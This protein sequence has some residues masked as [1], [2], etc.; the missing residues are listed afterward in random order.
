[1]IRGGSGGGRHF[2][3]G[4]K[5]IC[6]GL[7]IGGAPFGSRVA[8]I[9]LTCM[10]GPEAPLDEKE[11]PKGPLIVLKRILSYRGSPDRMTRTSKH[12]RGPL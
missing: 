7:R 11:L 1:M 5:P 4:G 2:R 8:P 12:V 3:V 6:E 10:K 9:F